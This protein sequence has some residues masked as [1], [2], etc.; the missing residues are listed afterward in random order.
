MEEIKDEMLHKYQDG[1]FTVT[2]HFNPNGK[3]FQESIEE[4]FKKKLSK[5]FGSMGVT[6]A[7]KHR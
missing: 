5:E 2:V 4:Y 7:R 6:Y 3:S 1:E